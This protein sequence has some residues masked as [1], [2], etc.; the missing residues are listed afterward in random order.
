M[1]RRVDHLAQHTQNLG[2]GNYQYSKTK[3]I[4]ILLVG[5][6]QTGKSTIIHTLMDPQYTAS[7][8]GFSDTKDPTLNHTI[9]KRI[10]S[11]QLYQVNILDT[12]GLKEVRK[13]G[14]SRADNEILNLAARCIQ[15][16]IT[17]LN[18]VCFVSKAGETH[19]IDA[20]VFNRIIYFLGER[21]A[22]I[23]VMMLTH[24]DRFND[25]KI[26][27]FEEGIKTHQLSKDIYKYC[28]LGFAHYGA[29]N[30][31][32][33]AVL[34]SEEIK[35]IVIGAT[36]TRCEVFRNELSELIIRSAD[37]EKRVSELE[38]IAKKNHEQIRI[39]LVEKKNSSSCQIQ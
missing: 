15:W 16:N 11:N 35:K 9:L 21:F 12:P 26:K 32:N 38:A 19:L 22:D 6:S 13:D 7:S 3:S 31:D 14:E 36:L 10:N 2:I 18:L 27:E 24:C 25:E 8:T 4:N 34:P 30:Y 5:R 1:E 17:Y 39:V 23:S 28:K 20:E 29:I 37:K 33:Y